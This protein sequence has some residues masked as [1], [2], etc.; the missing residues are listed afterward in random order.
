[1]AT[2]PSSKPHAPTIQ[3]SRNHFAFLRALLEGLDPRDAW[4]RYLDVL[5]P[6]DLRRVRSQ[7][8][9][10]L[11]QLRAVARRRGDATTAALLARDPVRVKQ[12]VETAPQ[13]S[14]PAPTA[15]PVA[16]TLEEF[17]NE[18]DADFYSQ[19]ELQEMWEERFGRSP[20]AA[21]EGGSAAP[22]PALL[23]LRRRARLIERQ[24]LAL[25]T[26]ETLAAVDPQPHDPTEGWL[27]PETCTRLKAAGILTLADLVNTIG[28]YGHRWHRRVPKLGAVGASRLVAWV[29]LHRAQL[30]ALP[31]HALAPASRLDLSAAAP[32]PT[33]GIVPLERLQLP[34][35][36]AG[37]DGSNRAPVERCKIEA[38]N[39]FQAIQAWLGLRTQGSH[40]WR[41]YRREAER[42]LMW[43]VFEQR[44]ALSDLGPMDCNLYR[45][46]LAAPS[47]AWIAT[48]ATQRW[49]TQWRP[50]EGP[51]SA[52]SAAVAETILKSLC[53][54]LVD[55]RYLDSNPWL[56][57]PKADRTPAK[58]DLRALSDKQWGHVQRWLDS[59]PNSPESARL[60]LLMDLALSTGMREA[61]LSAARIGWLRADLDEEGL[62]VWTLQVL[63]K[64]RKWRDV[65]LPNRLS[66]RLASYLEGRGLSKQMLENDPDLPLLSHL[67]GVNRPLTTGRIYQVI[68]QAFA[69]C[70][71]ALDRDDAG[72]SQRL[73]QASAHWLRHT[74][75]RKA[76][77]SG[78]E[79][80]IIQQQ[81]GHASVATTTIYL[82][83]DLG[84]RRRAI[85]KVF[86]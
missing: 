75:G 57:V 21:P 85:S 82:Q 35:S 6:A 27:A 37:A 52:R 77:D 12:L 26:L 69:R 1:M 78:V 19:Q 36:L 3:L 15:E 72:A 18:F 4:T 39:D 41:A 46:F 25:R 67:D 61:E 29:Q 56:A 65:P 44:K 53:Q 48:R 34:Q 33:M 76:A 55:V 40:T 64:G 9:E 51:L 71:A 30:G 24:L 63:G 83:G 81:L 38:Q 23:A 84:R 28:L 74:H 60:A 58:P 62:P 42:F 20:A 10:M 13:A 86:G 43:S 17:A 11:D 47:P 73:R 7:S 54:W 66:E 2:A 80:H 5:G 32:P 59:L 50:F 22:S 16:P 70:A 79:P 14:A 68:K 8:R 45:Q 49:S 31:A